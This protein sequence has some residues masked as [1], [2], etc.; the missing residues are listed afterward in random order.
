MREGLSS[1]FAGVAGCIGGVGSTGTAGITVVVDV[2]L[3]RAGDGA[4]VLGSS[5]ISERLG[6]GCA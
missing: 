2:L 6:G 4:V 3:A 1:F 5:E